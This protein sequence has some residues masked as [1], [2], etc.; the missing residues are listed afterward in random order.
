M[1]LLANM[2]TG[3]VQLKVV[4]QTHFSVTCTMRMLPSMYSA[5]L[6]REDILYAASVIEYCCTGFL[7]TT[8]KRSSFL[9]TMVAGV[10]IINSAC[11]FGVEKIHF[12]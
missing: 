2:V 3:G 10:T 1:D 12:I 9:D 4:L 5:C 7:I 6:S 11:N 8:P